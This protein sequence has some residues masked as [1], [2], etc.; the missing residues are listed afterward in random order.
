[1][2]LIE[3]HS[4]EHEYHPIA[5]G[6]YA[7]LQQRLTTSR[8]YICRVSWKWCSARPFRTSFLDLPRPLVTPGQLSI[9]SDSS[10]FDRYSRRSGMSVKLRLKRMGRTNAAFYRLSAIDSRSPRDG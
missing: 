5:H 7:P 6:I 8:L 10:K 1:M 2:S 9:L 4:H 3:K